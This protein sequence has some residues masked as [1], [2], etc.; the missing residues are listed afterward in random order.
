MV[1]YS[2]INDTFLDGRRLRGDLVPDGTHPNERGYQ[3]WA[4][5]LEPTL[6]RLMGD[7]PVA[8]PETR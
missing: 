2:S 6:S 5:A 4:E 1:S 7:E 3:A 8:P